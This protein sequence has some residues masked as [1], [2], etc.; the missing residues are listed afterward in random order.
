MV[1]IKPKY[2]IRALKKQNTCAFILS[3]LFFF[4]LFVLWSG[5]NATKMIKM[6]ANV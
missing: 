3:P 1:G 6:M 2:E 5:T 4:F